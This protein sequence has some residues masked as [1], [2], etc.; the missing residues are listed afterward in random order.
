MQDCTS[1][2]GNLTQLDYIGRGLTE[3]AA[4]GVSLED[5]NINVFR[6]ATQGMVSSERQRHEL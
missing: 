3:V 4:F 5:K 2:Y 6:K 1:W